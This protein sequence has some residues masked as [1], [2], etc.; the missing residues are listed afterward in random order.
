MGLFKIGGDI[1]ITV[2]NDHILSVNSEQSFAICKSPEK[3]KVLLD[4][5]APGKTVH[6]VSDGDWSMNDLVMELLKKFQPAE[7][8]ITSYAIRE[9]P[10]R[11]LILAQERKEI[12]CLRMLLDIRAKVRTP[13]VFQL[14]N[15]NVNQIKLTSIHAKVTV[16]R[17][18]AGCVTVVSSANWTANPRIEAGT[19]TMGEDVA[20]FHINWIQ[21][22][23]DNA[24]IFD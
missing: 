24:E 10:I 9:L 6:Y 13:E 16:I 1:D 4:A 12:L 19:V 11:Q 20:E 8:W 21:K 2:R 7:V 14:A 18:A 17:S 3:L 5:I 15:M 22:V 23:M